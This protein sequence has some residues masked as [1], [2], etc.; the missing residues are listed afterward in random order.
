[1]K[2]I[3]IVHFITGL[4]VGGAEKMLLKS[5]PRMNKRF[6]NI[7]VSP[8]HGDT[9]DKLK[10]N[11]IDVRYL[12]KKGETFKLSRLGYSIKEFKKIIGKEKPDMLVTYLIHA[13]LFG[14]VFGRLYGVK[15]IVCFERGSLVNWN[16]LRFFDRMS[17]VLVTHYLSVSEAL[18][19]YLK[20]Y[21]LFS[22]NKITV[23]Q[24]GIVLKDFNIKVEQAKKLKELG[25]TNRDFVITFTANLRQ[26]KGHDYLLK[27]ISIAKNKAKNIK[28]L[29]IG[30]D[31]GEESKIKTIIDQLGISKYVKILG[32]RSDVFEIL[33]TSN[34]FVFPSLHEGMSNALLEAMTAGCPIIASDILENRELI[35]N[36]K[37]GLLSPVKDPKS[38]ARAILNIYNN[39]SQ[40]LLYGAN[41]R[42]TI[43][44]QFAIERTVKRFEEA[45]KKIYKN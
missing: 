3:K 11:G 1:M 19:Y 21:W 7:V 41:A 14:R 25:L 31:Q 30:A 15:K 38:W 24:N 45:L 37:S 22:K 4:G 33:K 26:G 34:L 12:L 29:L 6:G 43:E 10:A 13:D 8:S 23:I 20:K 42:K 39:K 35:K 32:F 9:G 2:K 18:A 44:D 16:F 28:L 40:R 27:A 5:L 17:S 36:K